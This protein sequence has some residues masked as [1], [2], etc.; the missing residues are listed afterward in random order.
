MG[1]YEEPELRF[2]GRPMKIVFPYI[3]QRHQ[4]PHS[5]PIAIEIA[6]RHPQVE[7]HIAYPG[8]SYLPFI[9][10]LVD[11][12]APDAP[13]HF[14]EL[15]LDPINRYRVARGRVA[16]KVTALAANRAYFNGFDA[17]AV[18]ERTSL[19]L[20]KIGVHAPRLIWTR[21]GAG[22]RE[23]G[24]SPDVHQFDFV[25][26]AGRRVER[27]LL[28]QKLIRPGDYA[29]GVYAKFDWLRP[30]D[31]PAP[32]LFDNDRPTVLYNPHFAERLSSWPSVGMRV[33]EQ[34]A[35]SERYNLI[36]APHVRLFDPATPKH[37]RMFER[38]MHLPHLRI[39]LGS[40]HSIDMTYTRAADV[41]LGDVSSQ[42][43]EF[44]CVPRP[45]LFLNAHAV[46]WSGDPSYGFWTLGA[47]SEQ[48][49]HLEAQ[50]DQAIAAHPEY[51]DRQRQYFRETF[52]LP[53]HRSSAAY[54]A[55]AIV[56]YLHRAAT[57]PRNADQAA[58][59]SALLAK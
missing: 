20:R 48:V 29:V 17:I 16:W 51:R 4:I 24:F 2:T 52:E 23:V 35:A 13:L 36:F 42:I 8:P 21:H 6:R 44:M 41:Y 3:A 43:S 40:E 19:F 12:Y 28:E 56:D 53:E 1:I 30:G 39:D 26:M 14:D 25:L 59:A 15:G 7:V 33:L 46:S 11:E 47:V 55:D 32:R 34:F 45:C 50:I 49:E 5:L 54:G 38:F 27:R 10:R 57:A 58:S 22:D 9:R 37:Y 31:R 18:P